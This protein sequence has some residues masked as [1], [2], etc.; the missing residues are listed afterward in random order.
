MP[1]AGSL[2]R[3]CPAFPADDFD[4]FTEPGRVPGL[5]GWMPPVCPLR[6]FHFHIISIRAKNAI[7]S[8]IRSSGMANK[9]TGTPNH[10]I[11]TRFWTEMA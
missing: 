10:P 1:L 4:V 3:H 5:C 7:A 11:P 9:N 2:A 6:G 8:E